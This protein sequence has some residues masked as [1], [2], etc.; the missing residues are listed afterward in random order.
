[1]RVV[2]LRSLA[3]L[4]LW[5]VSFNA[6]AAPQQDAPR[7]H[8]LAMHGAPK[9]APAFTHFDY[10]N[11][12]A[13]KGGE[14]RLSARNTY[15]NL[16]PFILKGASVD[17]SGYVLDTL[18][19]KSADEP[20]TLYGLV[21]EWVQTPPDRSWVAFG[22]RAEARFHDGT[23]IT[24]DDVI[25]TFNAL[26]T[27]G[28]PFYRFYYGAV[29]DVEKIGEREVKFT[30]VEGD[31]RELP[32]I[33]GELPVLPE[34][35][36]KE[37]EFEK[38]TLE[39]FLGSGPYRFGKIDAGRSVAYE[40]VEDYWGKDLPVNRGRYNF[41]RIRIDYFRDETVALEAFK[42]GEYDLRQEYTSKVWAI[43]YDF[44]AVKA[45][46]VELREVKHKNST[47]MQGFA[48]NV[49]K[50]LFADRRVREAL[51]YAYNF[52][53]ANKQLFYNAYTRTHSYFSNS[54]LASTGMITS[55]ELALLE[56]YRER[57]PSGVFDAEFKPPFF[58][59][60]KGSRDPFARSTRT[61]LRK[62]VKLLKEAGWTVDGS[63]KLVNGAGEP[64][65]FEILLLNP[66]FERISL[67][68][69]KNLE[70]LGIEAKIRTVDL[71]QY[72]TRTE[73]FDFDMVVWVFGQSQSPG[74]EQRDFWGSVSAETPG[75]RNIIGIKDPVVDA[76]IEGVISAPDRE[77]LEVGTRALDRVLLWGH[78]IIPHWHIQSWRLAYWNK[79]GYPDTT[80]PYGLA[81]ETWWSK[82]A[83]PAKAAKQ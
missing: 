56:P 29:A 54:E 8:A 18:M 80:A 79:F 20:F 43:G 11:P 39:P 45:G 5:G 74:N 19:V 40:R 58:A 77:A 60:E 44:P 1:M 51:G 10:A 34:H 28:H 67:P 59:A 4:F 62:A 57:L 41:E 30:F 55:E 2:V 16:N 64:F 50:P 63:G 65:S 6:F 46:E 38:T 66:A 47:G 61:N 71:S 69:I 70:R 68:F 7:A 52:E 27:K 72:E 21:A 17:G 9:Y 76:L 35:Y 36:W 32:L 3:L 12:E 31:N 13:P 48:F 53:L 73:K 83:N 78:Y 42:A 24:A 82:S 22:I 75:G 26:K 15:D 81:L 23:P 14:F 37:R 25:F 49:R 33:L